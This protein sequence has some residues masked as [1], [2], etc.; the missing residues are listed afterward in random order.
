M[1]ASPTIRPYQPS[2]KPAV[3]EL[4]RLNTPAYFSPE[5]EADLIFYLENERED[6]FV[7]IVNEKVVGCGGINYSGKT[8][9]ISW[10]M[11]HP[12][13]QNQGLGR[14]LLQFRIS[15]LKANPEIESVTVRTSQLAYGF[16]QKNGFKLTQTEKDYWAAGFDLYE[17]ELEN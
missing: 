16:Y 1:T 12:D 2:D 13:Y 14:K 5:E 7:I 15:K 17:M 10:D 4:L 11:L 3:L 8:G 6:Y 9:K